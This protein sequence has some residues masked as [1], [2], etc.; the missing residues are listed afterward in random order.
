ML[1]ALSTF[2]LTTLDT[3]TRL[4]RVYLR[5]ILPVARRTGAVVERSIL[6]VRLRILGGL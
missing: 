5:G 1:L 6:T 4:G 3:A 2:I